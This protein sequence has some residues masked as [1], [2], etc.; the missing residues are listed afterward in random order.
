MQDPTK[1]APSPS[2]TTAAS[3]SSSAGAMSSSVTYKIGNKKFKLG[4]RIGSGSF[5]SI[6]HGINV[7]TGEEVAVK[8]EAT[9]TKHPQLLYEA[10]LYQLLQGGVGIPNL[11]WQGTEGNY[12]I[13]VID[14]LGQS[15]EQLF[16]MC[17]RKFSLKTVLMLA[18]Q[19]LQRLEYLHSKHVIHRDIKPDNFLM[20]PADKS[21]MLYMIDL[22]LAKRYRDP[23]S[24]FHIPYR[25]NKNLTGTA[26][27]ASIYTHLGIEQSRRD[28]LEALGY[29]LLYFARGSLP[30]Q[31]LKAETKTRKYEVISDKKLETSVDQLCRGLPAEF[32]NYLNYSRSLRFKD[33]PDYSYLR[34]MFRTLFIRSGYVY[35]FVYDWNLRALPSPLHTLES[36]VRLVQSERE[37][38]SSV[39][40]SKQ[41][42]V[43]SSVP[44]D[45]ERQAGK[46]K[47]QPAS[48]L[49]GDTV[50]STSAEP[51]HAPSK[52]RPFAEGGVIPPEFLASFPS[53][54]RRGGAE[55][56]EDS[57][58]HR[59]SAVKNDSGTSAERD[60]EKEKKKR[61]K[62]DAD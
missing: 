20:G 56:P 15:L 16:T 46:K 11:K 19:M 25:E 30:W 49:P 22:G 26:R 57:L 5:G 48:V 17:D 14:L 40:T 6:H 2:R 55:G 61:K 39:A 47:K 54:Q 43:Q 12:N 23:K 28:D 21:E 60:K 18:D 41:P 13:M 59:R 35:D 50:Y 51:A 27:Y 33:D 24:G 38:N 9:K 32:S 8:L 37:V 52:R 42:L 1:Y 4:K 53:P 7:Q 29:V 3:S 45:A 62:K 34:S 36:H 10:R 31:G 44:S 58:P